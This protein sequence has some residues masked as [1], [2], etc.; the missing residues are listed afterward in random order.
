MADRQHQNLY[1]QVIIEGI[2]I[3]CVLFYGNYV[4]EWD[5]EYIGKST[6]L[7]DRTLIHEDNDMNSSFVK[8]LINWSF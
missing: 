6:K 7:S 4:D 8:E 1:N 3:I 2:V 5:P